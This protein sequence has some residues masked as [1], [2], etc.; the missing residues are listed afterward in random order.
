MGEQAA[1]FRR[2]R[3]LGQLHE[4]HPEGGATSIATY[5]TSAYCTDAATG[6]ARAPKG[7]G[8]EPSGAQ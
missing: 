2:S 4:Y 5:A 6:T 3:A 7:Q 1:E 8:G